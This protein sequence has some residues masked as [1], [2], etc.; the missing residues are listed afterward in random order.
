MQAVFISPFPEQDTEAIAGLQ[1]MLN[2]VKLTFA[3]YSNKLHFEAMVDLNWELEI[4]PLE[5]T[6][7][8][9]V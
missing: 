1:M 6:K 4:Y 2:R 8:V 9:R 5:C 7:V 3:C